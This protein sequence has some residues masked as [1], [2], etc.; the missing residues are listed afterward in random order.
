MSGSEPSDWAFPILSRSSYQHTTRY[1]P[2]N[3][4]CPL[5]KTDS[6][7]YAAATHKRS[8]PPL[9]CSRNAACPCV[10]ECSA[11]ANPAAASKLPL[12]IKYFPERN[13]VLKQ[14]LFALPR[15]LCRHACVH[16]SAR[17]GTV[18]PNSFECPGLLANW[19]ESNVGMI[20][21]STIGEAATFVT[22]S[23]RGQ[24]GPAL[25]RAQRQL[26]DCRGTVPR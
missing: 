16:C 18:A 5:N 10:H 11:L 24:C 26:G 3:A 7:T 4:G 23:M 22:R 21:E 1:S 15:L 19:V 14:P 6:I 2:S 20:Q 12:N 25:C 8:R 13:N 17:R 9:H